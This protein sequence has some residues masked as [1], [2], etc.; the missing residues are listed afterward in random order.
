M[1]RLKPYHRADIGFSLKIWDESWLA[2]KP[3]NPFRFT[4]SSWISLEIF[5]LMDVQNEASRTWIKTIFNQQYA[6]PNHLTS[7]RIN[8]RWR[9]E[10]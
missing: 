6:I 5:N 1:H 9:A 3:K 4:K 10:F 7:R 8:L 2:Q